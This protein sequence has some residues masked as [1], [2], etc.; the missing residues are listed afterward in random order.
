MGRHVPESSDGRMIGKKM[1]IYDRMGKGE[2]T[3]RDLSYW[4]IKPDCQGLF[5]DWGSTD[6]DDLTSW[7]IQDVRSEVGCE[8]AVGAWEP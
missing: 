1:G 4:S 6:R 8:P 7:R 2:Q 5:P 3:T